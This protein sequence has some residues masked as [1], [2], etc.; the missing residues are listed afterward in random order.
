MYRIFHI[1]HFRNLVQQIMEDSKN[2]KEAKIKLK[3][4]KRQIGKR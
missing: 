3:E 2:A 1:S 4:Y